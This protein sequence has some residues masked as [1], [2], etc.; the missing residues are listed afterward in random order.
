MFENSTKED[1]I[2]VLHEMGETVYSDRRILELKQ[3]MLSCKA[4]L[5]D[6]EFVC[7]FLDTTIEDRMQDGKQNES[8]IREAMHKEE[9]EARLKAEEEVKAVKE[10]RK[11]EEE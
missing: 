5:E 4:Y 11:M 8:R 9:T 3:K 10:K 6:E 2:T 1:L 7:D